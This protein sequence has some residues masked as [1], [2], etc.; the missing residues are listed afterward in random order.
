MNQALLKVSPC[1]MGGFPGSAACWGRGIGTL[2][3]LETEHWTV[4]R[5]SLTVLFRQLPLVFAQVC[6]KALEGQTFFS[7][8]D[9]LLCKKHAHTLKL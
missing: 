8:K 9:K 1:S 7:K 4:P 5:C 6:N 2:K 3:D